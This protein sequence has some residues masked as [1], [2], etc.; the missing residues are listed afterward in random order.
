MTVKELEVKL[1][2]ALET[3]AKKE[4]LVAKREAKAAKLEA[5]LTKNGW[6]TDPM[7]YAGQCWN[8][9]FSA[10]YDYRD[11][12]RE[13]RETKLK[14]VDAKITAEIYEEKLQKQLEKEEL[15]K[16][17][18]PEAFKQAKEEL[19]NSWTAQDLANKKQ[20]KALQKKLDY[21]EFRE[22]YKYSQ[23]EALEKT[24]EQFRKAN[25]RDAQKWLLDLYNRVKDVTGEVTDATGVKWAG[26]AL[27][28]IVK[29]TNGTAVVET[30]GAGGYNIQ[31]YHLRVL[32]KA[33]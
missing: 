21:K 26:K 13:L 24:E 33:F 11:A 4:K 29:G 20:M 8:E 23:Q 25:E 3:V 30:I 2:K 12:V 9:A 28:G 32:V 10:S 14:L 16:T 6:S 7:A 5:V 17:E 31:R 15:I 22:I 18:V 27:N 19:V 1:A